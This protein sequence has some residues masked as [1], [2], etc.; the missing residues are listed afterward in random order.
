MSDTKSSSVTSPFEAF[1]NAAKASK[2]DASGDKDVTKVDHKS[3]A[4]EK[5]DT[6][7]STTKASVVNTQSRDGYKGKRTT[8]ED[9]RVRRATQKSLSDQGLPV[10]VLYTTRSWNE[11]REE[12]KKYGDIGPINH[13]I[14]GYYPFKPQNG[15]LITLMKPEM[16]EKL[17]KAGY[18]K[19][20][21]NRDND[22]NVTVAP[23]V[24]TLPPQ[25]F[26]RLHVSVIAPPRDYNADQK[27]YSK[28]LK[29]KIEE[30][31]AILEKK[32]LALETFGLLKKNSYKVN[33][34]YKDSEA[35]HLR[36]SLVIE[37]SGD[38]NDDAKNRAFMCKEF[39]NGVAW[40][41]EKDCEAK[42]HVKWYN[43]MLQKHKYRN[44][45]N[46]TFSQHD[47]LQ[48]AK[49][50][51]Q[52]RDHHDGG[53]EEDH[54]EPPTDEEDNDEGE[55]ETAVAPPKKP[56]ATFKRGPQPKKYGFK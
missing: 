5:V 28:V 51:Q 39:L 35:G 17:V 41:V 26:N 20:D 18:D 44:R 22:K 42:I 25:V 11:V 15:V 48:A 55:E 46:L 14:A 52:R 34:C 33:F 56:T 2:T 7:E 30:S 50:H 53:D 29:V 43:P 10:Y 32:L 19:D 3:T 21:K 27:E 1:V 40:D 47:Q 24:K 13:M 12:L 16:Y 8:A 36:S 31:K 54:Y 9:R 49:K 38:F 4:V 23:C 37:F 6:K 45:K